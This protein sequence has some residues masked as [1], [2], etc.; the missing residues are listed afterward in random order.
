MSDK[1][2]KAKKPA[3]K[4]AAPSKKKAKTAKASK[5]AKATKATK[6]TKTADKGT[7]PKMS[8]QEAKFNALIKS[9]L[10]TTIYEYEDGHID[11]SEIFERLN[12]IF[13]VSCADLDVSSHQAQDI[14]MHFHDS[15]VEMLGEGEDFVC[16][17][18]AEI[19]LSAK[20]NQDKLL[21]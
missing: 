13:R 15:Y 8:R 12:T 9:W 16:E 11:F 3:P 5:A 1:K 18:C 4:K 2:V 17:E 20:K 6:A 19:E 10:D 7:K 14:L 21:N